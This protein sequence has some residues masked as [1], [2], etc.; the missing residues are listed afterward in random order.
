MADETATICAECAHLIGKVDKKHD[1]DLWTCRAAL[2]G[3]RR[4]FQTGEIQTS[5][6]YCRDTNPNG[7]C[8]D[9]EPKGGPD[10]NS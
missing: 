2:L 7:N 4:N 10:D 6:A 9:Y 5:Y 8:H 1:A 3:E